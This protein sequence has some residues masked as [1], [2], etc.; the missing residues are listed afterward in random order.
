MNRIHQVEKEVGQVTAQSHFLRATW[1][2]LH[3]R[4]PFVSSKQARLPCLSFS[5]SLS[6]PFITP[7]HHTS[8][9]HGN[10]GTAS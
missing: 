5:L 4:R 7:L 3:S 6:L 2:T 8:H 1:P 9:T 10:T